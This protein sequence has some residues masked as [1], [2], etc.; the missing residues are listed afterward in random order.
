[1]VTSIEYDEIFK[2]QVIKLDIPL[3]KKIKKQILKIIADPQVGKPMQYARKG[4]LELYIPPF[5]LSYM[6]IKDEDKIVILAF[7]HKDEQ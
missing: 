3:R 4:T 1:M 6:H 2:K 7:Y 5:R